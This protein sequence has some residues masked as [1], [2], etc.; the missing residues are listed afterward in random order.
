MGCI[1]AYRQVSYFLFFKQFILY[2][3]YKVI[4]FKNMSLSFS[5]LKSLNDFLF[6][7]EKELRLLSWFFRPYEI[8]SLSIYT[9]CVL[10]GYALSTL[11]FLFLEQAKLVLI[12]VPLHFLLP[13]LGIIFFFF[14]II[15]SLAQISFPKLGLS[16]HFM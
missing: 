4:T 16:E 3:R 15:W 10:A 6:H 11:N 1:T 14:L 12:S 13:L 7:L 5:S 8:S 9:T 2:P